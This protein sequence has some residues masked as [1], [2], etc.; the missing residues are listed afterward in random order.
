MRQR[1]EGERG[2]GWSLEIIMWLG[3]YGCSW[4]GLW[5]IQDELFVMCSSMGRDGEAG[6]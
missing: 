4:F 5:F 3:L 2:A 6:G 1:G